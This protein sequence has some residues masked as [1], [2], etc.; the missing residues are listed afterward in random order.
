MAVSVWWTFAIY[1]HFTVLEPTKGGEYTEAV[2]AQPQFI[3]PLL[4]PAS[5][6]ST[7][8]LLSRVVFS[9]LFAYDASGNLIPDLA[10]SYNRSNDGKKYTITIKDNVQWHDGES[11]DAGDVK[12]T[13]NIT[14][15]IAYESIAGPLRAAWSEVA[16]EV[17]DNRTV[18]FLLEKPRGDFLHLLTLGMLPQH[19]WSD[20]APAQFQLAAFN[21]KP[22]GT[23]PY[24]YVEEKADAAGVMSEYIL[25][26]HEGYH[27]GE[28]LIT[29]FAFNFYDDRALSLEAY[30]DG[31]TTAV[32]VTRR[33]QIDILKQYADADEQVA[34]RFLRRP[35]Y[36][37]VFLNQ[38]KNFALSY[39][40]VRE[41][42]A[43]A[44]DR[45]TLIGDAF[46]DSAFTTYAP[47]LE[48]MKGFAPEK[49][50]ELID[51]ERANS[52]L[53]AK[54]WKMGEDGVRA[55]G[56]EDERLAFTIS[57]REDREELVRVAELLSSQW[58]KIGAEVT[59]ELHSPDDLE[60]SV[61]RNREYAALFTFHPMRWD[62]PNIR[63][64]WHSKEREYP[65]LNYANVNDGPLDTALDALQ[66][67]SNEEERTLL[68][69]QAQGRIRNENPAIFL[70]ATQF[71]FAHDAKMRGIDVINVNAPQDRYAQIHKWYTEE[72]S[73]FRLRPVETLE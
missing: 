69:E 44:T 60:S 64:L 9:G 4:A 22:I 49:K 6:S 47:L 27:F 31:L 57:V 56:G 29:K 34:S 17:I 25:R 8:R 12:F 68:Y 28:P 51:I 63:A 70:F 62:Q 50:Q 72:K 41:A 46:G 37:A 13:T 59:L 40:E 2:V 48:G 30:Q 23:G 14:K 15:D 3:N 66:S 7:D 21:L 5:P 1:K 32:A 24:K 36:F 73:V 19:I 42:L 45:D 55:R 20:V 67:E 65:G 11:F 61:I 18:E 26:A 16:V 53:D 10:E 39:K 38:N 43:L 58:Q 54:G 33:E 71:L 35:S 52:I